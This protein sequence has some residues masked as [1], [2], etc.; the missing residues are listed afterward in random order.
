MKIL[1]VSHFSG[2]IFIIAFVEPGPGALSRR[3]AALRLWPSFQ[4]RRAKH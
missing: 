1:I 3:L 4:Q 2:P